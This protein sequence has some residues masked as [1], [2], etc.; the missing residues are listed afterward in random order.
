MKMLGN[1]Q[2]SSVMMVRQVLSK[3]VNPVT[4][5]QVSGESKNFDGYNLTSRIY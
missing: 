5:H 1:N 4:P 2:T 3:S